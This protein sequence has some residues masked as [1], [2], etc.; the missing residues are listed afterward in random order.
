MTSEKKN[1]EEIRASF[2]YLYK[3]YFGESQIEKDEIRTLPKLLSECDLFIDVGASLGMYT[4]YANR[5]MKHAKIMAIEADPDR[6]KEL[7]TNCRKWSRESNNQIRAVNAIAGD[8]REPANFFRTGTHISGGVF[9]ISERFDNYD[10]VKVPQIMLDDFY[11][12]RQKTVV[13]IDVEGAEYR[14]LSGA[15]SLISN[16]HTKLIIGIHSWG[17]RE[18]KKTPMDVLRFLFARGLSVAKTS[19]RLTANYV[20]QY[21]DVGSTMLIMNYLKY[22]PF[23]LARQVYRFGMPKRSLRF[24]EMTLNSLRK[25]KVGGSSSQSKSKGI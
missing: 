16:V 18:R 13:K 9:T 12:P 2:E 5:F 23:L 20:F 22:A 15:T 8:S 4:Y 3:T 17:D 21:T 6:F 7:E 25:K 19:N 1:H 11:D 14:V 24:I 10:I